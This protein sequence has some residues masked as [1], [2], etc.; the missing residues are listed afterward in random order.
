MNNEGEPRV[1]PMAALT[2]ALYVKTG[3]LYQCEAADSAAPG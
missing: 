3:A 2:G 1:W